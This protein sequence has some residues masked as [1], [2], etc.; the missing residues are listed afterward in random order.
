M[1]TGGA[2]RLHRDEPVVIGWG[3]VA[4]S[5][6]WRGERLGLVQL[7]RGYWFFGRFKVVA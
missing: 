2:F 7:N 6:P 1:L 4:F 3:K 5:I